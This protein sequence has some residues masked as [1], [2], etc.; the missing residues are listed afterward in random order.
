MGV[1]GLFTADD[2]GDQ[3]GLIISPKDWRKFIKPRIKRVW[4]VYKKANIPIFH[5]SCGNDLEII[6]DLIE[7]EVSVL[8]SI[9][10]IMNP[11]ELK[12]RFGDQITFWG[13]IDTQH[14]LSFKS[15]NEIDREIRDLINVS[16]NKGGYI[17]GPTQSII[18]DV[19]V[20]NFKP[21]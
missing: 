18:S 1:D 12:R 5:H 7:M 20:E 8:N 13:G 17:I 14:M 21:L 3:R 19:P 15:P 2:Y 10:A 11:H 4:D 9:Q 16:N 6:H